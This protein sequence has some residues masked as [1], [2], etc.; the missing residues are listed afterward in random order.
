MKDLQSLLNGF[1][2]TLQGGAQPQERAAPPSG[3]GPLAGT[4]FEGQLGQLAGAAGVGGLA[5]L[6]VGSKTGR[7][8]AGKAATYGGLALLGGLAYKAY[9]DWQA[10]KS[11]AST[12]AS[13]AVEPIPVPP[14]DGRFLPREQAADVEAEDLSLVL[15]CAMIAAAKADGHV[16]A[17]EQRRLFAELGKLELTQAQKALVMDELSKPLDMDAVVAG[18]TSP[19]RAAEIYCASL[20][21]I[22]PD[23]PAERG[24]LS[25]LAGR[26]ALDPKLVAHLHASVEGA[27]DPA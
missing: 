25:F 20:M 4:P 13:T 5:G 17:E 18:A 27:A 16:D 21:A 9:T 15:V 26:L 1:L 2:G 3:S 12:A 7:K 8:F 19:E 22:D 23:G 10:G 6:L 14:V 11:P 24:Y